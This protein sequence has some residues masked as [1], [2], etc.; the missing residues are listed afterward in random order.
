MANIYGCGGGAGGAAALGRARKPSTRFFALRC[1]EQG[2]AEVR[3][4]ATNVSFSA[5]T[6]GLIVDST[7]CT[8]LVYKEIKLQ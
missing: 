3:S 6:C 7:Y 8:Y 2:R 5:V 4:F 1:S